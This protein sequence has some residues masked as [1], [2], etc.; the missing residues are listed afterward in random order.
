MKIFYTSRFSIVIIAALLFF[1]TSEHPAQWSSNTQ[2]NTPIITFAGQQVDQESISD[3]YGGIITVWWDLRGPGSNLY[4]QR[5]DAEGY[6]QWAAAGVQITTTTTIATGHKIVSD[7][8]GGA[9]VVWQEQSTSDIYAQRIN[10]L[11]V[12]QWTPGGVPVCTFANNQNSQVMT[13]VN[14]GVIIAWT[15]QRNGGFSSLEVGIYAQKLNWN[16]V[17]QWT[18]DGVQIIDLPERQW[19][20]RI[21]PDGAN[22]AIIVYEDYSSGTSYTTAKRINAAGTVLWAAIGVPLTTATGFAQTLYDVVPDGTGGLIAHWSDGRGGIGNEYYAQKIDSSGN[23]AWAAAGVPLVTGANIGGSCRGASD[24]SGGAIYTFHVGGF[25]LSSVYAQRINSTGAVQWGSPGVLLSSGAGVS[26]APAITAAG[27]GDAIVAWPYQTTQD[28]YAQKVNSSGSVL[29][30]SGGVVVS[31]NPSSQFAPVLLVSDLAGGAIVTFDDTR[32]GLSDD[33]YAQQIGSDGAPGTGGFASSLTPNLISPSDLSTAIP[34]LT[35]FDWSDVAGATSYTLTI[36]TDNTFTTIVSVTP[37]IVSSNYTLGTPLSNFT[38]YYWKVRSTHNFTPTGTSETFQFQ[39]TLAS[40]AIVSPPHLSTGVTIHPLL[41]WNSV[42]GATGYQLQFSANAGF[43]VPLL[44]DSITAGTSLLVSNIL[45]NSTSYYWRVR[46]VNSG[47]SSLWSSASFTTVAEVLPYLNHPVNNAT[48]YSLTPD[49]YWQIIVSPTGISYDVQYSMDSTFPA[50]GTVTIDAGVANTIALPTLLP[51]THYYWRV[52]SKNVNGPITYSTH[53]DFTTFGEV[54]TVPT[55]TWPTGNATVYT[56][57]QILYWYLGVSSFGYTFEVEYKPSA[58][59]TWIGPTSV[60]N[61]LSYEITGLNAGTSYDWRVR[62]ANGLIPSAWSAT[63]TFQTYNA[64]SGTPVTPTIS[65]PTDGVTMYSLTPLLYWYLGASNAGLSFDIELRTDNSFTGTP[66]DSGIGTL[67][68]QTSTLI[69]GTTYY[70][71]VRS[72][73]GLAVSSWSSA[74]SF[75]TFG[76]TNSLQPVLTYPVVGQIVYTTSPA[77]YWYTTGYAPVMNYELLYSVNSDFTGAVT[78]NTGS[79]AF[80]SLS[81]L[82]PGTLYYWKVRTHNGTGYSA[83]SATE[84]FE[85]TG[86]AGT[87]VPILSWPIGGAASATNVDLYWYINGYSPTISYQLEYSTES[88][89]SNSVVVNTVAATASLTGLSFGTTYYWHVRTFNGTAWSVFSVTETF[90]TYAGSAPVRPN[91]GS[92]VNSVQLSTNTPVLSWFIPTTPPAGLTYELQYS[93][94]QDF[95]AATTIEN[96]TSTSVTTGPLSGD[97]PVYW[98]VRSKTESGIYSAYSK[99]ERFIPATPTDAGLPDVIPTDFAL[100]QNYPNPFNPTT[101]ISFEIPVE[102]FVTVRIYD[103][104]GNEVKT[105]VN[106]VKSAGVYS[107]QWAGDNNAGNI[108]SAGTYLYRISA[109]EFTQTKKMVFLK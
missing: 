30:T 101:V 78:V 93:V 92:P 87:L 5:L 7:G 66:T 28:V 23:L 11:G 95:T 86:N 67:Y 83:F 51:G 105:L 31:D 16:G 32:N 106:E 88:D 96:L 73:N 103:M 82:L 91:G 49:V 45:A 20:P 1:L 15:D 10:A 54:N 24:G 74:E 84:T 79:S 42:S 60:G 48:V 26:F 76:G 47:D 38:T 2:V 44:I 52:R 18:T 56:L 65:Y 53:E 102:T 8:L 107:M 34:V 85:V 33:I 108:V 100:G 17:P 50:P 77:L 4:M 61:A 98:R 104:L 68:T 71:R 75:T 81:G 25:P 12:V 6:P 109:G 80:A 14:D 94:N 55:P 57:N 46:A 59:G 19:S 36:A 37:G 63:Q 3:G 22:G 43:T 72:N 41:D 99:T 58:S 89:F 40:P 70:F 27:G 9:V 62:S 13:A 97:I 39:T 35:A 64:P 69:P 21:A 29:W 90:T